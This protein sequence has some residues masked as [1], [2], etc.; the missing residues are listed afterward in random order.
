MIRVVVVDWHQLNC[1]ALGNLICSQA[2]IE[3]TAMSSSIN[4]ATARVR[5]SQPNVVVI[6]WSDPQRGLEATQAIIRHA[7]DA[8]ILVII[9]NVQNSFATLALRAGA[10]GCLTKN[11]RQEDL[12]AAIR[13]LS[14]G[15]P[16]IDPRITQW[17]SIR[18]LAG[19][20]SNPFDGLSKRQCEVLMGIISGYKNAHIAADLCLS[21]KTV[22]NHKAKLFERLKVKNQAE[23][24]RLAIEYGMDVSPGAAL[25]RNNN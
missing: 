12:W 15:Q 10:I 14:M 8:A 7:P 23:L 3:V 25:L 16:H 24:V 9:N 2:D 5:E 17:F 21:P 4:E 11:C 19:E 20:V 6:D 1:D 13:D 18:S 22:S